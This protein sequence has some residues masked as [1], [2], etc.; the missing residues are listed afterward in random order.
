[1]SANLIMPCPVTI[2]QRATSDM[3]LTRCKR[4]ELHKVDAARMVRGKASAASQAPPLRRA[5]GNAASSAF[6]KRAPPLAR[7]TATAHPDALPILNTEAL[8]LEHLPFVAGRPFLSVTCSGSTTSRDAR[9]FR[10]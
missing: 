8:H 10:Q 5:K 1:M 7:A 2:A 3:A 6:G 4:L 9:H